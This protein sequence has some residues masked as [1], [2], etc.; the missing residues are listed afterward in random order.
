MWVKIILIL[1]ALSC[2]ACDARGGTKLQAENIFTGKLLQLAH[3]ITANDSAHIRALVKSGVN[4]NG[5]GKQGVTPLVFA[6]GRGKKKAFEALLD[7]GADPNMPITATDASPLILDQSAMAFIAGAPDNDY[8]LMLLNHGGDPNTKNND[9]EP[10]TKQMIFMSPPNLE[11]MRILLD[12][13]ADINATDSSGSTLLIVFGEL[14]DFEQVY[15]LLQRGADYRIK[16]KAGFGV[17]YSIYQ[18]EINPKDFPAAYAAQ[19]K[20]KEFMQAHGI[21]DPGRLKGPTAY[22]IYMQEE[23]ERRERGEQ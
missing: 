21:K 1:A 16:D 7:C 19:Y 6:F 22:E 2:V 13:G 5:Y 11:G 3:A 23:R 14:R 8:L 10:I 17:D 15:Y 18:E 4:P 12:R 9:N 20:C